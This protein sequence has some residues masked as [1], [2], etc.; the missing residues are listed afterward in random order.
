MNGASRELVLIEKAE[1]MLAEARDIDTIKEIRDKAQAARA[2]AKKAGLCK[3][4]ILH[5]AAIKV[6]AE[7][8]L[9]QLL[10]NLPLANSAPGNQFT[11]KQLDR[12]QDATG[13]IRLQDL[14]I[15]KSD[16]S[17]AQ[18]IAR[19]PAAVF[20]SYVR[21]SIDAGQEPTT[22]GLL[23]LVKEQDVKGAV[24]ADSELP[25]GF[26]TNLADLVA[27][28]HRFSTIYADPPW[29]FRDR[30]TRGAA[31]NHYPTMSTDQIAAEPVAQLAADASHLHLWCPSAL[32]ADALRVIA[33]W[34][35]E[36][37]S[38]FVWVKP[39]MGIGHYWRCSHELMLLGVRKNLPFRDHSQR[40]WIELDR[41]GHSSKPEAI[42]GLVERVSP[43]A[44]LELYGRNVPTNQRWT[45]H[46]NQVLPPR[47]QHLS[48]E[49]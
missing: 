11:G 34:G 45:V 41:N 44:Y 36:Y 37:R 39:Q 25:A 47:K 17:R 49:D 20:N 9:G 38:S 13:P 7:R 35:F 4:I 5:A 28:G 15:T 18:Q 32:L 46:G 8:R 14:G 21:E 3:E 29:S 48:P 19:L 22:A 16:S 30:A 1:Q 26:V 23:R 43:P 10:A 31:N 12:S 2:Y 33:A 24:L 40:S 6:Q 42:R 27:A